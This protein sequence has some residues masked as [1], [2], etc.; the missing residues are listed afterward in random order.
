MIFGEFFREWKMLF[1]NI[2]N[3]FKLI[4]SNEKDIPAVSLI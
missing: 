1:W 2:Q 4:I 3:I